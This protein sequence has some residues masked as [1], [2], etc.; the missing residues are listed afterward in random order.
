MMM[1]ARFECFLEREIGETEFLEL[2][3]KV[4]HVWRICRREKSPQPEISVAKTNWFESFRSWLIHSKKFRVFVYVHACTLEM[5][6]GRVQSWVIIYET[7]LGIHLGFEQFHETF[8]SLGLNMKQ[9]PLIERASK[10]ASLESRSTQGEHDCFCHRV[11][12]RVN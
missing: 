10:L 6:S 7:I 2:Q 4:L 8:S 1:F 12:A 5:W 3:L 11:A 9:H